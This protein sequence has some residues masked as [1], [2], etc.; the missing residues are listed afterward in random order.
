METGKINQRIRIF[1]NNNQPDGYG[2]Y[3]Q[4]INDVPYWDTNAQIKFLSSSRN[5]EANQTQLKPVVN[6][7]VRYRN[8]K[9]LKDNMLVKWR[10][11]YFVI[12]GYIP[13]VVY[14]EYISF[15]AIEY[16]QNDIVTDG[17]IGT[18]NV[19]Y[20]FV[21][22][23]DEIDID[24]I[25]SLNVLVVSENKKLEVPFYSNGFKVPVLVF[26]K[27][28]ITPTLYENKRVPLDRGDVGGNNDFL[29]T[30]YEVGNYIVMQGSYLVNV[31]DI[32]IFY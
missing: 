29:R 17:P 4:D 30:P 22:S 21:D 27:T 14:Q 26:D 7:K 1:E 15:D 10:G 8:D 23:L 13:Q 16:Q 31:N 11:A 20:G 28:R 3:I 2:G 12:Q 9:F 32:L 24:Q 19:R 25:Q 6:F 18:Y 5:L